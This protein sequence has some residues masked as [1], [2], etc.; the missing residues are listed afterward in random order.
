MIEIQ[1]SKRVVLDANTQLFLQT[2]I[3]KE[4]SKVHILKVG[5]KGGEKGLRVESKMKKEI[6]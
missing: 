2:K 1:V 6:I 3:Y 4:P 5:R